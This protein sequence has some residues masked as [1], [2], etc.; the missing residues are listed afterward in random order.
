MCSLSRTAVPCQHTQLYPMGTQSLL[1]ARLGFSMLPLGAHS[2]CDHRIVCLAKLLMDCITHRF[3][4]TS[5]SFL[6]ITDVSHVLA[7]HLLTSPCRGNR[8]GSADWRRS[9]H[10]RHLPQH[11]RLRLPL[12][13]H[14]LSHPLHPLYRMLRQ[15]TYLRPH[16]AALRQCS[17]RNQMPARDR[18]QRRSRDLQLPRKLKRILL[19]PLR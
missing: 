4:S 18:P 2:I 9:A 15:R 12:R 16:P 3:S 8:R 7:S 17:R 13:L 14:S 19:L 1:V 5:S 11:L 6:P 10:R